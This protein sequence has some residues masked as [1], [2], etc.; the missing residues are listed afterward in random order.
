M[1]DERQ[2]GGESLDDDDIETRGASSG[3]GSTVTATRI[4]RPSWPDSA[5]AMS[6]R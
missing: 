3:S 6:G 2:G 1:T 4:C 5:S